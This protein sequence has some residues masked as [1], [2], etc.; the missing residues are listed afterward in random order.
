[1]NLS[2]L[3]LAVFLGG[4]LQSV[5]VTG[6]NYALRKYYARKAVKKLEAALLELIKR[7]YPAMPETP[8][9]TEGLN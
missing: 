3:V 8:P 6:V 1:M 4:M 5:A 9:H 2:D 7:P